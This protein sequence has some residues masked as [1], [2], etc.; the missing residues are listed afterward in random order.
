MTTI[1]SWR[2]ATMAAV[3]VATFTGPGPATA[4]DKT[5]RVVMHSDLKSFDP[6]LSGAPRA[7]SWLSRTTLFAL[8]EK[9]RPTAM[10]ESWRQSEDGLVTTITLRSGLFWH[11]GRPVTAEDCIASL[12]RWQARIVGQKLVDFKGIGRRRAHIRDRAEGEVRP[13]A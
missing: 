10:A 11:D 7:Q 6:V 8:D 1:V 2:K 4:Q 9:F 3:V 12:K 13:V 5:L